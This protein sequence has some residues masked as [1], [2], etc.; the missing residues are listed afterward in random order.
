V[1]GAEHQLSAGVSGLDRAVGSRRLLEGPDLADER[2]ELVE[3]VETLGMSI[4]I[5]P[6]DDMRLR[7][8][9]G[10]RSK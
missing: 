6:G 5:T 3:F 1:V 9:R 10:D 2:P 4:A 8:L 7:F